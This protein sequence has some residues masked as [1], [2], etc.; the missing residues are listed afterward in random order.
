MRRLEAPVTGLQCASL[1]W[2]WRG[3]SGETVNNAG[4]RVVGV[5]R[6]LVVAHRNA[7]Q[8]RGSFPITSQ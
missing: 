2:I 3:D 7:D 5:G 4:S 8:G 6:H 1:R